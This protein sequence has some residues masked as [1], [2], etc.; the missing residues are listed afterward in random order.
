MR[1]CEYA[2]SHQT[3]YHQTHDSVVKV[4]DQVYQRSQTVFE[5][6]TIK[7]CLR[8]AIFHPLVETEGLSNGGLV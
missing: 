5:Y 2:S 4:L 6:S 7:Y 1:T 8:A 3:S